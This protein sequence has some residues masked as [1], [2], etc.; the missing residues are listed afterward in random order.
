MEQIEDLDYTHDDE[1]ED[2][3]RAIATA[4]AMEKDIVRREGVVETEGERRAQEAR[5]RAYP[6]QP[7]LGPSIGSGYC[8]IDAFNI[9][10]QSMP[11]I[12]GSNLKAEAAR[13]D[14]VNIGKGET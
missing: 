10:W 14:F 11:E 7:T 8:G 13:Q 2:N 5:S 4:N 3:F 9:K 12:N 6:T 1:D